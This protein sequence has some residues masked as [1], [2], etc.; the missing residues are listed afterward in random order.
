MTNILIGYITKLNEVLKECPEFQNYTLTKLLF[1]L[2]SMP[3]SIRDKIRNNAGGVFNHML[4]F[5][6]INSNK[7]MIKPNN[8]IRKIESQFKSM[9]SFFDLFKENASEVFGSGYVFLVINSNGNLDFVKT[10]NQ[11]SVFELNLYPIALIDLW[12]HAYYLDYQNKRE[13]YI[14]NFMKIINL[15]KIEE[16]Y[17]KYLNTNVKN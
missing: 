5:D 7:S 12:E 9:E 8:I 3:V 17:V 15:T 16:R 4:Y 14:S 6:I 10:Q 1:N 2:Y 11:N 13:E